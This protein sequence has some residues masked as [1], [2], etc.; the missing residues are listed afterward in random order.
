MQALKSGDS[1]FRQYAGQYADLFQRARERG[2]GVTVHVGE[3][4]AS[5]ASDI[6]QA[7]EIAKPQRIGHGIQAAFSEDALRVL[8][9]KDICLKICPTSNLQTHAVQ[10]LNQLRTVLHTFQ[11]AGV[12]FTINTD[13]P[14]LSH[15]NLRYEIDLLLKNNILTRDELLACFQRAHQY[16]F[17]E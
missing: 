9:E 8:R 10:D 1:D 2:L 11:D 14:Y 15:T 3:T 13:N 7:I 5:P 6:L 17:I 12:A 4:E 16:S